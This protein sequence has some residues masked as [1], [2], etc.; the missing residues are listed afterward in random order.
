MNEAR[1]DDALAGL[2]REANDAIWTHHGW[3]SIL[4]RAI[5]T[6]RSIHTPEQV[7]D[8]ASCPIGIWLSSGIPEALRGSVLYDATLRA[9]ER[10]H[11]EAAIVLRSAVGG[12]VPAALTCMQR[13]GTFFGAA[14]HM[15][16]VLYEWANIAQ[17]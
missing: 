2:K 12:N 10:F 14:A 16:S 4:K 7:A 11:R 9:H 5:E 6:K 3:V 15:R 17:N 8:A 13:G 1:T